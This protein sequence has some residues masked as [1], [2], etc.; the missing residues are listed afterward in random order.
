MIFGKSESTIGRFADDCIIYREILS[1]N[2]VNILQTYLN[3]LGE[4]A[5]ENE[6]VINPAESKA[7]YFTEARVKESLH[8][9]LGDI[10]IPKAKSCTYLGS[11]YAVN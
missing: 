2:D 4:W 7:V 8:Y 10:A 5:F 1:N 6:M 11:F 9:S 3:K